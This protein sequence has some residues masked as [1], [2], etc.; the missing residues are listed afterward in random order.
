MLFMFF[1]YYTYTYYPTAV[2]DVIFCCVTIQFLHLFCSDFHFVLHPGT[3]PFYTD[4]IFPSASWKSDVILE[5]Q[6]ESLWW[7]CSLP[8]EKFPTNNYLCGR[9]SVNYF[10]MYSICC[11]FN[12]M[13]K[14]CEKCWSVF[15]KVQCNYLMSCFV[16]KRYLV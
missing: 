1:N 12:K 10:L 15:P 7:R 4:S 16:R 6:G 9:E 13:S 11:F 3:V 2:F 14:N 8:V 5:Q